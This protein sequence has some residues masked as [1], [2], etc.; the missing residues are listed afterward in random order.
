MKIILEDEA[1]GEVFSIAALTGDAGP[2]WSDIFVGILP[3]LNGH[4]TGVSSDAV[5]PAEDSVFSVALSG[6]NSNPSDD[7]AL[8]PEPAFEL[9][10]AATAFFSRNFAVFKRGRLNDEL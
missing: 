1:R 8:A 3:Q 10:A 4:G 9:A 6:L 7:A 5:S 2:R